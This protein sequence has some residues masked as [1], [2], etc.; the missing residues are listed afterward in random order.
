MTQTKGEIGFETDV[1]L[2]SAA[3]EASGLAVQIRD[4]AGAS[5]FANRS[6]RTLFDADPADAPEREERALGGRA[7]WVERRRFEYLGKPF[8]ICAGIDLDAQRRLQDE[9]YQ[10]AFFDPLTSLPNRELCDRAILELASAGAAGQPFALAVIEIEKFSEINAVHGEAAGDGLL[11]RIAER[12][13]TYLVAGEWLGRCGGDQFCIILPDQPHGEPYRD[14]V[15]RVVARLADPFFV[16]GVE[17]FA[18]AK[19]GFS[20]FPGDDEAADG[21][22]R[23][24]RA[25]L[26]EAR[27][28]VN[29]RARAFDPEMERSQLRRGRLEASLRAAIRD[30][31]IG[32]AFQPKVDF[33]VGRVDSLEV[34]MRWRDEEGGWHSPGDFLDVAHSVGLIND[35]TKLVFD[36]VLESL[37]AVAETFRPDL[38]IGF[39]IAARQAG[40]TRFMRRFA[41]DLAKSGHAHRFVLELT[42]EAFLPTTQFQSRVLPMLREIGARISIDDFGAGFSSLATLADITADEL[43]VDRSLITEIDKKPRNQTLLRA[44]ESIGTALDMEVMVEG[45]ETEDELQYIRDHTQIRVAQGYLLGRPVL[46]DR[47]LRL[48]RGADIVAAQRDR[49]AQTR[50]NERRQA[51]GA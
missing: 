16:E 17:V 36:E 9:L 27:R 28:E 14:R 49:L 38:H 23:K 50:V 1:G 46:L 15:G 32:C 13:K 22:W 40:D 47:S 24:A 19:G 30:R 37:D 43:K 48:G 29:A 25:A 39:N 11:Q 18:S 42:E 41:D 31:R 8:R 6:A 4:G 5:I 35:V 20:V 12:I 26:A 51:G 2:V 10:R 34:L 3:L 21:L 33:R 7:L 44:I 45:V